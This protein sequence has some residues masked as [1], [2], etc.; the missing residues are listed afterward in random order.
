MATVYA[1]ALAPES[2]SVT[3]TS[4][5]SNLDLTTVDSV[6]FEVRDTQNMSATP[7]SWASTVSGLSKSQLTATYEFKTGD[8]A[9]ATT[10]R[11]MPRLVL[12]NSAGIRRC[13]PF[14]LQVLE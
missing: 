1:G 2:L 9:S 10:L 14:N 5:P 13:V 8:V 7:K 6:T 12:K 3:I 11:I 4:G